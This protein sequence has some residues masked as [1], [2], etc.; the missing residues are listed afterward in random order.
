LRDPAFTF[1]SIG[2]SPSF[3][4]CPSLTDLITGMFTPL[5]YV[6]YFAVQVRFEKPQAYWLLAVINAGSLPGRVLPGFF[7]DYIGAFNVLTPCA[8]M[9]SLLLFMWFP[10]H[11]PAGLY[12]FAVLYGFFQGAMIGL[13]GTAMA[14]ILQRSS[15]DL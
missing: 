7:V 14:S 2:F 15:R 8:F 12:I 5:W 6:Q 9:T 13:P 10:I 3:S 1:F 4:V 11:S